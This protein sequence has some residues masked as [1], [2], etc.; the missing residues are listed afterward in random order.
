MGIEIEM[1]EISM[2]P[3]TELRGSNK[4]CAVGVIRYSCVDGESENNHSKDGVL[5]YVKPIITGRE[6]SDV[7][8]YGRANAGFPQQSTGDQFFSESQFESYRELGRNTIAEICG[9]DW[10][11]QATAGIAGKDHADAKA[12]KERTLDDFV[13]QVERYV[14][15][16]RL[17][18]RWP[19]QRP[20]AQ[21]GV[22]RLLRRVAVTRRLLS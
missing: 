11:K 18:T 1:G 4:A 14:G 17:P 20:K 12:W 8:H 22:I 15:R 19:C 3:K 13:K 7:L 2:S 16:E 10:E 6:P 21:P 5:I 9:P